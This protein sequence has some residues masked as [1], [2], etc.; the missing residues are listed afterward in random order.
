MI[1]ILIILLN[2]S[3]STTVAVAWEAL[4]RV[5]TSVPKEVLPSYIK[6]VRDAVSTS[7]DKER[8]K[9]KGGLISGSAEQREQAAQGLG[10]LVE[11]TSEQALKEFVILITGP[12]IR[13]IGDRFP[14]KVKSTILSTL[15]IM[16]RKG[17]MALKPFLPQLQ[18][19]F[20]KCLQD[21]TRTVRSHAA[22]ALGK[23]SALS[24][25]VDP[26]VGDLVSSLQ[27]SDG[28]VRE[29][30]LTALKGVLE[31]AGKSVS[32][33]FRTRVYTVLKDLI[34]DDGDQI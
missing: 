17:G 23:L 30:I 10:E 1:S 26:L 20:I 7:R 11:V 14:W 13:I 15:S 31:Y 21:N 32:S 29:A 12:L 28:G 33:T 25:R 19:T 24:T 34:Y 18:T 22:V 9:R 8:G 4:S 6:L 3:D 5:F 27:A 16:I 2:D